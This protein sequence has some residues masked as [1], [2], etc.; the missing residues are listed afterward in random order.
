M[1]EAKTPES[2]SPGHCAG[3]ARGKLRD[4]IDII[5]LRARDSLQGQRHFSGSMVHLF[6]LPSDKDLQLSMEIP[7]SL[8]LRE[9]THLTIS[10]A[11]APAV[12]FKGL[13]RTS[14]WVRRNRYF[15]EHRDGRCPHKG[16]RPRFLC[17]R[18]RSSPSMLNLT[19]VKIPGDGSMPNC[20]V[21]IASL[22][23]G[24]GQFNIRSIPRNFDQ[25]GPRFPRTT[26][27][28]TSVFESPGDLKVRI[29]VRQAWDPCGLVRAGVEVEIEVRRV[30]A[31]THFTRFAPSRDQ[32]LRG[33]EGPVAGWAQWSEEVHEDGE[34]VQ[35]GYEATWAS[36]GDEVGVCGVNC[37]S[38]ATGRDLRV[39]EA[40]V[41]NGVGHH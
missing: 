21:R 20:A 34:G 1:W 29:D 6:S 4:A 13:V 14:A 33:F 30:V 22:N 2:R 39:P 3:C 11:L 27:Q 26:T 7:N 10:N 32:P 28:L 25:L 35:E 8:I 40:G 16:L 31:H 37:G 23:P 17:F 12:N 15:E 9:V 41:F 18:G 19:V 24:L 38:G 36:W 5:I